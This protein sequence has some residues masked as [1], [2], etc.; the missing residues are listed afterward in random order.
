MRLRTRLSLAFAFLALLPLAL[1]VPWALNNLRQTLSRGFDAQIETATRA[2]QS[3]LRRSGE[4]SSLSVAEL[5][6]SLAL[7]ELARELRSGDPASDHASLGERLMRSRSLTVLSVFDDRGVTLTSG[8]LPARLGDPDESLFAATRQAPRDAVPVAVEVRDES[9]L[10]RM[11]ALVAASPVDYG[12]LRLWV[13]GGVLLDS[14]FATQL[15]QQTGAQV[16]ITSG[17]APVALAGEAL[18]P[19]QEKLLRVGEVAQLRLSFSRAS[20][21]QAER[22]IERAFAFLTGMGL[23]L[24]VAVGM[25][26]ARH[27]TSPVEALTDAARR[28]AAGNLEVVVEE[29]ATGEVR[30]LVSTFNRMTTELRKVT[31]QLVASERIAAWQEVARRLAHEIKNPLTPIQMSLE[32]L[33]AAKH[34]GSPAFDQLFAEGVAAMLEEV[35]RLRRIVDEFSHFARLPKPQ[36]A[37]LNPAELVQQV[38]LLYPTRDVAIRW[39]TQLTPG[40]RINA[41]RDQ[42]TQVLMNLL[43]NAE[44]AMNGTG[45]IAIRVRQKDRDILLEVQDSGPGVSAENRAHLFEPYFTTKKGGT[46]LGLAIAARICQ[47]HGGRLE[48]ENASPRGALFRVVLPLRL[49]PA[50]P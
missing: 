35:D 50:W 46:G 22:G 42:L 10:R 47:E 8:H 18:P 27:I 40:L 12:G 4:T 41:D 36:L 1:V 43:K 39:S 11:P 19:I 26:L 21:V 13:V 16:R 3:I 15:A 33:A 14:A 29:R 6:D 24:A 31:G 45:E 48:V 32:T 28:V 7:E 37:P 17:D 38:L 49:S 44:E 34:S 2:T 5:S 20:Q 30:E 25:L 23:L 9:G